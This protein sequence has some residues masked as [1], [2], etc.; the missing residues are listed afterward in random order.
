MTSELPRSSLNN[1]MSRLDQTVIRKVPD[2]NLGRETDHRKMFVAFLSPYRKMPLR[3]LR[4]SQKRFFPR[5]Q[6]VIYTTTRRYLNC[7]TEDVA[8]ETTNKQ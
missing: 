5:H 1:K 4:L 3:Y 8:E 2:S 6:L 7:A